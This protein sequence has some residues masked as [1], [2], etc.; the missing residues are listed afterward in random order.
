MNTKSFKKTISTKPG[1]K[2]LIEYILNGKR[3]EG[4]QDYGE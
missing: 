3:K 1:K 2:R 4:S